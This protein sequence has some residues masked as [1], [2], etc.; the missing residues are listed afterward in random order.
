MFISFLIF[1]LKWSLYRESLKEVELAALEAALS[2]LQ[3]SNHQW[4]DPVTQC[5]LQ[6]LMSYFQ[7]G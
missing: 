4:K 1:D 2:Q 6:L 5:V 7:T 3:R